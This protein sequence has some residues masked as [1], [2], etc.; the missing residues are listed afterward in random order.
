ME[1][2]ATSLKK[3]RLYTNLQSMEDSKSS[4]IHVLQSEE[5]KQFDSEF[6][7][8]SGRLQSFSSIENTK[9]DYDEEDKKESCSSDGQG[10][11][12]DSKYDYNQSID[13]RFNLSNANTPRVQS[14]KRSFSL[15]LISLILLHKS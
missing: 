12:E 6:P 5:S 10:R 2:Y 1:M 13:I 9:Y 8:E 3:K 4:Q 11:L 15:L 14:G 7:S